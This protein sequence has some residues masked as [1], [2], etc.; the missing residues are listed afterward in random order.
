MF[1]A[2]IGQPTQ[3]KT[4]PKDIM[5]NTPTEFPSVADSTLFDPIPSKQLNATGYQGS[6]SSAFVSDK[7]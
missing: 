4:L 7:C 3:T 2:R 5:F 6:I 1:V